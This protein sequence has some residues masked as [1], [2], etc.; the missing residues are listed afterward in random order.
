MLSA[1]QTARTAL[2]CRVQQSI[3]CG[4]AAESRNRKAPGLPQ[5][6]FE[7]VLRKTQDLENLTGDSADDTESDNEEVDTACDELTRRSHSRGVRLAAETAAPTTSSL[8]PKVNALNASR[9]G[10]PGGAFDTKAMN[11]R[12]FTGKLPSGC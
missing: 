12:R 3:V 7:A 1:L 6:I 9:P 5:F 8:S 11:S 10:Y 4:P 2:K